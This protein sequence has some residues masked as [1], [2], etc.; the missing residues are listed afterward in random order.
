VMVCMDG[1]LLTHAF[2]EV[3]LPSQDEVDAFLP[4]RPAALALDPDNPMTLGAMVGPDA[5]TEVRYLAH[6]HQL[7]A[8]RAI[9]VVAA[10]FAAR[11]GRRSGGL[12]RS[13]RLEE[14]ETV[15]LALGSINGTLQEVVDERRARREQVGAIALTT[16]R[17]FPTEAIRTALRHARRVVVVEKELVAGS[18]GVLA[19]DVRAAL[20]DD[21][22]PGASRAAPQVHAVIAGLGGRPVTRA[23]LHRMLDLATT[24]RLGPLHW[25]DLDRP[26]VESEL[27]RVRA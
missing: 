13:Y 22:S 5:F 8:L 19:A 25:L 17:P 11:F 4:R 7:D 6:V 3:D 18:G 24:G 15:L 2:E 12:L 27:T 16:F 26:R 23:S 9:A 10:E 14:A 21:E 20:R 1:Y